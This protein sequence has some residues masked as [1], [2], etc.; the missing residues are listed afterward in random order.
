MQPKPNNTASIP[1]NHFC[2]DC[3]LPIVFACCNDGMADILPYC[4]SDYWLYCSNK[5]CK[6]HAG[7]EF[8]N[9]LPEFVM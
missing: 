6:N 9:D 8:A 2:Q 7:E 5:T 4:K 3:G 1:G